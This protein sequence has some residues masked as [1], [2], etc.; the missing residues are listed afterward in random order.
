MTHVSGAA[1]TLTAVQSAANS[2]P[3]GND[4]YVAIAMQ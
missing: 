2:G 4:S 3:D 1:A